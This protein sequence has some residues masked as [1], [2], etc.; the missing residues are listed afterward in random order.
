MAKILNHIYI[1]FQYKK[2]KKDKKPKTICIVKETFEDW[3]IPFH[4]IVTGPRIGS[5]SFGTVYRGHWHGPVALKKL[6]VSNPTAAQLQVKA[7]V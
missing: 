6:D 7:L 4:E 2:R 5:G 1:E 3:E